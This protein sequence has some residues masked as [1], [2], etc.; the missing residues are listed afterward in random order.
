M[1]IFSVTSNNGGTLVVNPT[2]IAHI[3]SY[4]LQIVGALPSPY[5]IV[6]ETL[7]TTFTINVIPLDC[8]MNKVVFPTSSVTIATFDVMCLDPVALYSSFQDFI[9]LESQRVG[10][11]AHCGGFT[12]T[13]SLSGTNTI[14]IFEVD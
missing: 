12:Y 2:T 10:N 14:A 13:V 9:D 1:S 7:Q 3:G 11:L 4:T 8:S 6:T 5:S